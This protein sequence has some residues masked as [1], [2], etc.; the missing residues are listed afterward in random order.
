MQHIFLSYSPKDARVVQDLHERLRHAGFKPWI[1]PN[2]KP[3]EDWR[4]IIDDAIR[5]ADAVLVVV[6]SASAESVYVTYEWATALAAGVRVIPII[7]RG[8]DM[9]P[10]LQTLDKLDATGFKEMAQ[11]WD[12]CMRELRRMVGVQTV[13]ARDDMTDA[14]PVAA[15]RPAS[16]APDYDRSVMPTEPGH[17]LIVRRGPDPNA[18]YRLESEVI[19]V[20]RDPANDITINDPEVSRYH[21]R[22]LWQDG[23]FAIEDLGSTNGTL[24]DGERLGSGPIPLRGGKTILL[25][26]AIVLSYEVVRSRS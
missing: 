24:I 6:T 20:G 22:L 5:A 17:W 26:D 15:P 18:M 25:G 2:P 8:A 7:I 12:Y 10:R 11:F 16:A 14:P 1:D 23:T 3:G 9:H 13:P 21:M 19:T 4:F